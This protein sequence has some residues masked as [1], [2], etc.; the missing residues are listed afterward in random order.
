MRSER[1][2][3]VALVALVSGAA[4]FGPRVIGAG[5][6]PA[7]KWGPA[8]PFLPSGARIAVMA[9]DPSSSGEFT[10]RLEFPAGY[11]IKPHWHPTD[12]HVTVL[13]GRFLVGMGDVVDRTKTMSLGPDGFVTASAQASHFAIAVRKTVVQVNAE[14]PFSITYVNPADDPRGAAGT[15]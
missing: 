3:L 10:I 8:P 15:H 9:G 12:E 13:S 1:L 2:A 14:G 6:A 5:P 11:V 7:V 4:V